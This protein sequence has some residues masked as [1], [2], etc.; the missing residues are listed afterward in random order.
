[1]TVKLTVVYTKPDDAE[2]WDKHY[3]EVHMPIVD[4]WAG[5]ERVEVARV[6]G[7]PGGSPSAN[8]L[9]T[10]IYFADEAALNAAL[11]S[12]AGREA[13]KDFMSM[14]PA[15]SSMTVSEIVK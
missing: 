4:R 6:S 7:G 10:E 3:S 14:A 2:A 8:H 12:D 11:G 13:G 5:V 9:I 15:G 1:M